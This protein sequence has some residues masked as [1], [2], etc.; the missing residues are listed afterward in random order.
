[1]STPDS[2]G[3]SQA[4]PV[5]PRHPDVVAYV[6]CQ[7]CGRPVCPQCQRPAAVG[8]QC[9]DCVAE[10]AKTIRTART[11][12]GGTV[13]DGRPLVTMGIIG[14]CVAV[15]VGELAIPGFE[16]MLAFNPSLG[17]SEPWRFITATFL[18]ASPMHILFN[19]LA[20][21][22][23]G[24]YLELLLGRA[25][26]LALY[27]VSAIGG[28][29]GVVLIDRAPTSLLD[30]AQLQSYADWF[31]SYVGASG[32]VFGLF[33]AFIVLN[34]HLGRSS[35]GMFLTIAANAVIGFV[36]PHI[37]WQAHVGGLVAG[38]IVAA[39]LTQAAK[40]RQRARFLWPSLVTLTVVLI[41]L[42][43][44]KYTMVPTFWR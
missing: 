16:N 41:G 19:M 44:W 27:L 29:V 25:R 7:R 31:T 18:H 35:S 42:A 11:I 5:C 21:W 39:V 20:L 38:L 10:G 4:P 15:Y 40:N 17:F 6:R 12:Y 23:V 9:V 30:G 1:M 13:T 22:F 34:R 43:V 8:V 32:A 36:I 26:Y 28:S 24:P 37:A 33:G 3:M 14:L 2:L